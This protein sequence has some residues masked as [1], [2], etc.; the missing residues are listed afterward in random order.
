MKRQFQTLIPPIKHCK[1]CF[2]EIGITDFCRFFDSKVCLC[3]SC[4]KQ[5]EPKFIKFYV[6]RY[7]AISLFEYTEFIKK[8][9]YLFKGCFDYEM[10]DIFLNLFIK[11]LKLNYQGYKIIAIPSYKNDDEVRGF[12]HV[13]EV[14]K[15]LGLDMLPIIEKTSH[16]KQAENRAKKR[17]EIRKYLAINDN[18]T[19][20]KE[21][22]LIVDDIYTTGATIKAAINL[23]EKLNPKEIKVLVLAKTKGIDERK[24]N[25]KHSLH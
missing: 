8:Q 11:E 14:F 15:Q 5:L 4:Q 24:S 9:I 13:M 1:I 21:R 6:D 10:K 22:V 7:K 20:E 25:T 19:L 12:N 23:I 17:Q 3:Q 2:K 16:F 18:K